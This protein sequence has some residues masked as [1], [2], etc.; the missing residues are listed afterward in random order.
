MADKNAKKWFAIEELEP[1]KTETK[2]S[3]P[4]WNIYILIFN[5]HLLTFILI[6][7]LTL[8]FWLLISNFWLN[9]GL[10]N[11][12]SWLLTF[13]FQLLSFNFL[14]YGIQLLTSDLVGLLNLQII[15]KVTFNLYNKNLVRWPWRKLHY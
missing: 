10:S 8:D 4:N 9:F 13:I 14:T 2:R 1:N 3:E 11:F 12:V 6:F 15:H 7:N 5:F